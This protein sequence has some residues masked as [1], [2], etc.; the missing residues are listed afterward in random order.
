MATTRQ[1][2]TRRQSAVREQERM[3]KKAKDEQFRRRRNN[4]GGKGVAVAE[5]CGAK[6]YSVVERNGRVWVINSEGH[7][8]SWPPSRLELVSDLSFN[9]FTYSLTRWDRGTTN[10]FSI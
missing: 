10:A 3:A 4:L 8:G 2:K 1:S 5:I 6:Y 7:D 9:F